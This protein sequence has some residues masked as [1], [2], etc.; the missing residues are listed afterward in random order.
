M[1]NLQLY[2]PNKDGELGLSNFEVHL[3]NRQHRKIVNDRLSGATAPPMANGN[4]NGAAHAT[5]SSP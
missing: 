5:S 2:K 3:K 1:M 4:A